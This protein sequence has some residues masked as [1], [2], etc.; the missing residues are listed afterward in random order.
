[1]KRIK[2]QAFKFLKSAVVPFIEFIKGYPQRNPFRSKEGVATVIVFGRN[3]SS[4]LCISRSLGVA[5]YEVDMIRLTSKRIQYKDLIRQSFPE[6]HSK[7][8]RAFYICSQAHNGIKVFEMLMNLA[9]K[10]NK[11]CLFPTDDVSAYIADQYYDELK[12]YYYLPDIDKQG[13]KIIELMDKALQKD[14]AIKC[15]IRAPEGY[16]VKIVD[17]KYKFPQKISYPCFIKPNISRRTSKKRIKVCNTQ[18]DLK[19]ALDSISINTDLDILVEEYIQIKNE[20]SILGIC[21]SGK[22]F[23]GGGFVAEILGHGSRRGVSAKGRML[24]Y[25]E[26]IRIFKKVE[27]LFE[28]INYTGLFDI[29]LIES[30]NGEIYFIE[31]NFRYG[32]SG[33][34]ITECGNNLPEMMMLYMRDGELPKIDVSKITNDKI[35]VSEKILVEE[36]AEGYVDKNTMQNIMNDADILFIKNDLDPKPFKYINWPKNKK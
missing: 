17:G 6:A 23:C 20:I 3:Y 34:A 14:I 25:E 29:D 24:S 15:G 18:E 2:K 5:G 19:E 27:P 26:S 11:K 28:E 36:H 35:F 7:Y 16:L 9:E 10:D 32:A 22:A 4:N 1:M 30:E 8:T 33:Y 31:I 21:C 13:F 12:E